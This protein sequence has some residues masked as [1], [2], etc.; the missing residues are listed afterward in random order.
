MWL[1]ACF[2]EIEG[3]D[4]FYI[5]GGDIKKGKILNVWDMSLMVLG[6]DDALTWTSLKEI[7]ITV[8]FSLR[9]VRLRCKL[10]NLQTA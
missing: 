9:D 5:R 10:K 1:V 7:G 4:V 6:E 3:K 2:R 8:F